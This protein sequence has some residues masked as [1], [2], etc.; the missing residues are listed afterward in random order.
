MSP[1][2]RRI[3]LLL[4]A[5]VVLLFAGRW[6]SQF[7]TDL[8]WARSVSTAAAEFAWQWR[9]LRLSLELTGV[10]VAGAWFVGHLLIFSRAVSGVAITRR[11]GG[12]EIQQAL[13]S[14]NLVLILAGLGLLA[15]VAAGHG[16]G[17]AAG[18]A[19]LA[20]IGVVY[21]VN[22]PILGHD[23]GL[24][25]AQLPLWRLLHAQALLLVM[26]AIAA[27]T[28]LYTLIGALRWEGGRLVAAEPA[29]RHLG[30]LLAAL[31]LCLVWGSL[32]EPYEMVAGVND[33]NADGLYGLH[34]LISE[35]LA[36][37]ALAT[38]LLSAWW[39]W[40]ARRRLVVAAWIILAVAWVTGHFL[41]PA[42]VTGRGKEEVLS[43]KTLR[44]LDGLAYG[45][46]GADDT[47][48]RPAVTDAAQVP[49]GVWDSAA[50]VH[51]AAGDSTRILGLGRGYVPVSGTARPA[52]LILRRTLRN[53]PEL[54]AIADDRTSPLGGPL[55]Y[56]PADTFAYPRAVVRLT[57]GPT[58]LY[59]GAP[60]FAVD[61]LAPG[62]LVGGWPRRLL[63]AWA[64]QA[65]RLL[66]PLP[67]GERVAWRLDPLERLQALAPFIEWE[68]AEPRLLRGELV[69]VANGYLTSGTFPISTRLTWHGRR[70]GALRS[71][72]IGVIDAAGGEPH[73]YLRPAADPLAETWAMVSEG[74]LEPASA[75][76]SDLS[77]DL[78]Y[79]GE[80][81]RVQ[82]RVMERAHWQLG[83]VVGH[84]DTMP[85]EIPVPELVWHGAEGRL[86]TAAVS[87]PGDGR[88]NHLIEG[89]IED[90]WERLRLWHVDSA[91]ALAGRL[92][93]E[94]R[95][96]RSVPFGDLRDSV[97]LSGGRWR[98]A[99]LRF[100]RTGGTLAASR[101]TY[102]E[103]PNGEMSLLWLDLAIGE[104]IGGGRTPTEALRSLL[105]QPAA[106]VLV[107]TPPA[108][109]ELAR[110]WYATAD[111]ALKRS[112]FATFGR[113]F[114]A[115]RRLL[116][117]PPPAHK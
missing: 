84:T 117:V 43:P 93:L 60:P 25:V 49:A 50:V 81:F 8:W 16:Q 41:V 79:P 18:S 2:G 37:V 52:W 19:V 22:D 102:A 74:L 31:A 27:I 40:K 46:L 99:G 29:R 69:W 64:L 35:L 106:G 100:F 11:I 6:F 47:L 30:F 10:A 51:A 82:V 32:L 9:L 65:G 45:L 103:S 109:L 34:R 111:S 58:A 115:L 80:A 110:R 17:D 15:G 77:H 78:D 5:V 73:I 7:L 26:L 104:R 12:L 55:S 112:D 95:W 113:A 54:T 14:R 61:T 101:S 94:G 4:A 90:G 44:Q 28:M 57:L 108:Q 36:G 53:P 13:N 91:S 83:R 68:Q 116:E 107:L 98:T 24:Y 21:G 59:P 48:A 87:R 38:A 72:C 20:F 96:A 114:E 39:A 71:A 33:A 23:L 88:I 62:P 67:D 3:G 42:F 56:A 92:E 76:P 75:L 66:A 70:I 89:S 85:E 63:L 86:R 105:G 97:R 1:R